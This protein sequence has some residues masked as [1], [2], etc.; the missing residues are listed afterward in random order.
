MGPVNA[1]V[2][3]NDYKRFGQ[4]LFPTRIVN[5]AMGLQQVMVV[6]S[7]TFDKV[8]PSVFDPP[9]EIKALIK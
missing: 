4:I 9:D 5:T 6:Q 7:V 3:E 2:T 8:E 1:T